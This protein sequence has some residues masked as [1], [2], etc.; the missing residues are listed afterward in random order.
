MMSCP[1]SGL[2][3]AEKEKKKTVCLSRPFDPLHRTIGI[4]TVWQG[5]SRTSTSK[6][7]LGRH[8]SFTKTEM[9]HRVL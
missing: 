9:Q 4:M 8:I 2:S 3:P 6:V 1:T 7:P 5:K